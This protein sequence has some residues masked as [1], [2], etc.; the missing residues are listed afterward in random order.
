MLAR[1][2]KVKGLAY[3]AIHAGDEYSGDVV[4]SVLDRPIYAIGLTHL[5]KE[6]LEALV[7]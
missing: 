1:E 2:G 4:G 7:K 5:L 3:I 6:K